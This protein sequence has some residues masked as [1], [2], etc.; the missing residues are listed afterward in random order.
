MKRQHQIE[1]EKTID[2]IVDESCSVS[3]IVCKVTPGGGKSALPIIA[4]KLIGAGIVDKILWVCPRMALQVQGER[5][6]ID[7][8]FRA[9]FVHNLTI[10]ASTNEH[11]PSRGLAGF[12]TTYQALA[13]DTHETALAAVQKHRYAVI[14]DE[15]H[16]LD[17][18]GEWHRALAAIM[19][20]AS[21]S[22]LMTGT[23]ERGD[24][25]K[26]AFIEYSES[27]YRYGQRPVMV[28]DGETAII[29]YERGEA[30]ED[31]A[32]LPIHFV[33]S[34]GRSSWETAAGDTINADSFYNVL[35]KEKGA[36]L[37]AALSTEFAE[38]LLALTL[39]HYLKYQRAVPSAKLLIVTANIGEAQRHF[40]T[41]FDNGYRVG[42]ATSHDTDNAVEMIEDF[43]TG[44]VNLL[45]TIAM[46]Y[47][48]L[49]VP[50][51]S[52]IACLTHIRSKP[53]IEQM[54]AR[55]VRINR[56]A[57]AWENQVAYVFAPD[58]ILMRE[59]VDDIEREQVKSASDSDYRKPILTKGHGKKKPSI[60]PIGS[61]ATRQREAK[62]NSQP[63]TPKQKEEALLRDIEGHIR[64]FAFDNRL[65][66]RDINTELFRTFGKPRRSMRY[67]ELEKL[68]VHIRKEYP[69]GRIVRGTGVA[70]LPTQATFVDSDQFDDSFMDQFERFK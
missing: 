37:Y 15:F 35:P 10:R 70:R 41:L 14:L 53:W 9:M 52:H 17:L 42:L 6:F 24:M 64:R 57:G 8:F 30:L 48:G 29:T 44:N 4:G 22:V 46:A 16:H 32:I 62:L 69:Q 66:P 1:F 40:K 33:F 20:A 23:L 63:A 19:E 65:Q 21:F 12:I 2:A 59:I 31:R 58:D 56:D 11:D 3:R 5:N 25:N 28:G 38:D 67:P 68:F 36:A 47:E 39:E 49:D 7:P 55:A 13:V 45:V 61:A 26:I 43:K 50:E 54:F 27:E 34:D 51:I 18:N 60:I